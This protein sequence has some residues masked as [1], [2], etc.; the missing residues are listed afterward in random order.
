MANYSDAIF[1]YT[2]ADG[3]HGILSNGEIWSTAYFTT[4]DASELNAGEGVLSEIFKE[5]SY[6][7]FVEGHEYL[8]LSENRGGEIFELAN[9]FES[10]LFN[11]ITNFLQ[12]YITC[13]CTTNSDT[14]FQDGLLS[15]WRGYGRNS[16]YAL[17]FSRSK[18]KKWVSEAGQIE[19]RQPYLLND[20]HYSL[21]NVY[22]DKVLQQEAIYM[23]IYVDY[24]DTLVE[25][26]K[27]YGLASR[28]IEITPIIPSDVSMLQA[29]ENFL[30]YRLLTKNKHFSEENECRM[31]AFVTNQFDG[32]YFFN[33]NGVLIPYIKTPQPSEYFLDCIE[34]II[35][36]PGANQEVRY[37]SI[38][39]LLKSLNMEISIRLSQIPYTGS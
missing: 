35:V 4:N 14:E 6:Q 32:I 17:Q 2:N 29:I 30:L 10:L 28:L 1:H 37:Q 24:L 31:S 25:A 13:F 23:Q 19:G 20:V 33:R 12:I 9:R 26:E 5:R 38:K 34:A 18:L 15:Q 3:L 27:K 39:H 8:D 21:D 11:T 22:R 36:G 7:L 16:G